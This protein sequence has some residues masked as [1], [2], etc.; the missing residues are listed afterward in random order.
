M[1]LHTIAVAPPSEAV[2]QHRVEKLPITER[3]GMASSGNSTMSAKCLW[4]IAVIAGVAIWTSGCIGP[5]VRGDEAMERGDYRAALEHYDEAF[6]RGNTDPDVYYRA[7]RAA[8]SHGAFGRAERY[9]SQS[10]R[11]GGGVDV[12]KSLA[13][14]YIQ[15][16]NFARAVRVFQYLLQ[17]E[18]DD[19]VVQPLY[20]NL[21]TALMYAGQYL[22]AETY[23]TLAQE[24]E[25]EDPIPYVN[26]GVLYDRHLRNHPK[27]V[28]FYECYTEM[29]DD[30]TRVRSVRN[31][32][33]EMEQRRE[34]DTS[35]VELECGEAYYPSPTEK[36]DLREVF[37]L[38][39]DDVDTDAEFEPQDEII[40]ERLNLDAPLDY[41]PEEPDG[42]QETVQEDEIS[43]DDDAGR[44]VLGDAPA[45]QEAFE[46][47]RYDEVVQQLEERQRENGLD[48]D[49]Q[50]LLG[51]SYYRTG[52]FDEAAQSLERVV[53]ER[54]TPTVVEQLLGAYRRTGD[55][56]GYDR[57]CERFDNW[58]DYENVLEECN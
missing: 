54:P 56:E 4:M 28:R 25:P 34:I 17:I 20:S 41:E 49:E 52:Q 3:T 37:E 43:E 40:I 14:F 44:I 38:E 57:I 47:G 15:T 9:Y 7:A 19:D 45:P 36:H 22:D 18:E 16:N 5:E 58:P 55:T 46:S 27:A 24:T 53:E 10:L 13:N 12:A 11:N 31:R 39:F 51:R 21:G 8:Q 35:R 29:S 2:F 33:R 48:T 23:L 30:T 50:E 32:L 1:K 26:L 42:D 6:E